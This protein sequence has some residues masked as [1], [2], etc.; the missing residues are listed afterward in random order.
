MREPYTVTERVLEENFYERHQATDPD[1]ASCKL[2]KTQSTKPDKDGSELDAI[3]PAPRPS[4]GISGDEDI[5]KIFDWGREQEH[6][7]FQAVIISLFEV[8]FAKVYSKD[9][10]PYVEM[11]RPILLSP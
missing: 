4:I 8:T 7:N 5:T 2:Y 10:N 9:D 6:S 3:L 1:E 11:T